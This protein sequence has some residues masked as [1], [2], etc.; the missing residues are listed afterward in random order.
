MATIALDN[1]IGAGSSTASPTADTEVTGMCDSCDSPAAYEA[2]KG[3]LRL[4]FC[5]HHIRKN[6]A[7]LLD[8]GFKVKPDNYALQF[9]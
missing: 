4:V 5:G 8:R 1:L 2:R 9:S 7:S 6:S 3:N